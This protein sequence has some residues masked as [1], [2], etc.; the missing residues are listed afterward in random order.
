LAV[1]SAEWL[2]ST[3]NMQA[4]MLIR[5]P[6]AIVSSYKRLGWTHQLEHFLDQ[7]LLMREY[8]HPYEKEIKEFAGGEHDLIEQAS[9]LWKLIHHMILHYQQVHPD[10]IYVRHEDLSNNPQLEYQLLFERLN[11]GM[12]PATKRFIEDSSISDNP[13]ES[14]HPYTI[15]LNSLKTTTA[16]KTRLSPVEIERVYKRVGEIG[17]VFYPDQYW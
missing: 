12:S 4:V 10:W 3:F 8:L 15:K 2:A 1:F 11:L 16:W 9:L 17:R 14:D 5:H 7:P 13:V 6:A